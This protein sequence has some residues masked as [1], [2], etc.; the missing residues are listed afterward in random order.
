MN[1]PHKQG[2]F[3]TTLA[4][5][6]VGMAFSSGCTPRMADPVLT[7][8]DPAAV[9]IPVAG[10]SLFAESASLFAPAETLY[11]QRDPSATPRF[12]LV[13]RG[14]PVGTGPG[15]TWTVRR[16]NGPT[17]DGPW[18]VDVERTMVM[19]AE[20]HAAI[21]RDIDHSEGVEV[22]FEPPMVVMPKELKSSGETFVQ[23]TYMRVHPIGNRKRIKAEGAVRQEI[24]HAG[25]ASIEASGNDTQRVGQHVI[26]TFRA[27]LKP[28]E[29]VNVI[30]QWFAPESGIVAQTSDERTRVLGVQ[31]RHNVESWVIDAR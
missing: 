23:Q 14:Q 28:A 25:G 12:M 22:I 26:Q 5:A 4:L 29:V 21:V 7:S 10:Q 16:S 17:P 24:V 15:A 6:A 11:R 30:H 8:S 3:F 19:T 27:S 31:I 2:G 18:T 20:G 13:G 9:V 1:I